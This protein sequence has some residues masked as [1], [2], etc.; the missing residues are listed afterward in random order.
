MDLS[1]IPTRRRKLKHFNTTAV[2][3]PSLHYMV[4]IS[5]TINEI[6][7]MVDKGSYFTINRARQFGKT[8]TLN[9]LKSAL[10]SKYVVLSMSFESISE[11]GFSTEGKFVKTFSKLIV[12]KCEF[13]GLSLP[14]NILE[15]LKKF[16]EVT[17][18]DELFRIIKRWIMVSDRPIVLIIDEVD[19]ATNNQ[20]FIDFLSQLR[21]SYISRATDGMPAFQSVIL[22]GVTDVKHLKGK[23]REDNEQKQNSPWNIAA[24]FNVDMSLSESGIKAMLDEYDSDYHT[25][26]D[27]AMLAGLLR[28]YTGGYP[29]LVSRICQIIDEKIS[30]KWNKEGFEEAVKMLLAESNTLFDSL[31]AKLANYPTLRNTIRGILMSGDR[32]TYNADQYEISQLVMYGFI[33]NN[34]NTIAISN[35]IFETRLYNLFLSDEELKNDAF[36]KEGALTKNIFVKEGKLDMPLIM[37]HFIKTY[38]QVFGPLEDR[39]L[40]KDGRELFLL[41]IKPII[42]GTGNYYIEAQTR[43]QT[44]TDVIIDYLGQQYIIELKI[45]RGPRYNQEGEQQICDY[46]DYFNL[47]TGYMLS[48]NFNKNK[49]T[50]VKRLNVGNKV[51]FEGML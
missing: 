23:I 44:R 47:D 25:N 5:D 20:V 37:D 3:V 21:A 28:D 24:D 34:H 13:S 2:C 14:S 40:E 9:M 32:V 4:D 17:P 29:F 30:K 45:W 33:V 12:D 22:A 38:T 41:Y 8:T 1:V 19:S 49:E 31:T 50:G 16:D 18:L 36:S 7:K 6:A 43:D 10:E 15:G 35:R 42:N 39:F 26:M 51:L 46:L 27:T 48:F 11:E